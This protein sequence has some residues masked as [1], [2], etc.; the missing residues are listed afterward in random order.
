M[1]AFPS[2]RRLNVSY[3]LVHVIYWALFAVFAG[4]QTSLLL[5]RGFT[6]GE[7]GVFASIRCFAG[8]LAQP[9]LGGWADRHPEV[10]I[11]RL[12][13]V[14]LVLALGVNG[15][16]Y[17]TR[18]GFWGT[19]VIFLA[20]GIL[21]L[22]AY[23]LLDSMAVQFIAA[24]VPVSYSLS[25][26]LGS[27]SYALACV[28]C[29]QQAVRFGT[30][31]LLLTHMALL[32]LMIAAVALYPAFPREALPPR[33]QGQQPHSILYILKSSRSFTLTL[34]SLFFALAAIMPIVSF[35]VNLVTDRGGDQG[36]LGLAL[37]LMGASELP[38]ALLFTPLFRRFGA[39]GT[40]RISTCFMAVKPLLFLLAPGLTGLLLVQ[41]IQLLGYGLFTPA[42][43]YYANANVAPEDQVKGQ[44]IMMIAS[45]GLGAMFGKKPLYTGG[46]VVFCVSLL[47]CATAANMWLYIL[48]IALSGAAQGFISA[49]NNAIIA[50]VVTAEERPKYV[51]YNSIASTVVQLA[52]PL[53]SGVLVD[54]FGWRAMF[55]AGVPFPIIAFLLMLRFWPDAKLEAEKKQRIDVWGAIA[56]LCA[57]VPLLV[58]LSLGGTMIPWGSS[59]CFGLLAVSVV[60]AVILVR[61]D[62]R[63]EAPMISFYMFKNRNFLLL[64][65]FFFLFG[66]GNSM[67]S[68]LPYYFQNVVG[69]SASLSGTLTTPRSVATMIATA[70]VGA[71]N[72]SSL[73]S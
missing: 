25:R 58:L 20:L 50:D 73:C 17:A 14:C 59:A 47:G 39:A 70:L 33:A 41:P 31:S 1:T 66:L 64:F 32:V 35:M 56:F 5:G 11:K 3:T 51:S 18:P 49:F 68:Y 12:L 48:F 34:V 28:V 44:S 37:F 55:L 4:Y 6:S 61:V 22:N 43:V 69:M 7:A 71:G 52:G 8:I 54:Q 40:L 46:L 27:L 15:V 53:L 21:E 63:H 30:E 2:L 38:A 23:P 24:G 36:H 29:G 9:L 45:N 13:N 72:T 42:S 57:V 19:A 10:P 26:G 67:D 60:F 16:F 65:F 62:T